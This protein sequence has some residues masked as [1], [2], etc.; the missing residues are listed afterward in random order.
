MLQTI[1]KSL[2]KNYYKAGREWPYKDVKPRIIAETYMEDNED[3]ELRDYKFF[4][5]DGE[6]KALFIATDRGRKDTET[7]FDFFD[8]NF[9]HLEFTNGHPNSD[10]LPHKPKNFEKMKQLAAILSK[11]IPHARIDFYEVDEKVLFGEITFSHW[12]GMVPFEPDKW[13][14]NFGEWINI[15]QLQ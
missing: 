5:F 9:N 11:G 13:D 12:S 7:K 4:A 8:E 15:K 10:I 3:G 6:V 2:S 1:N 14:Y